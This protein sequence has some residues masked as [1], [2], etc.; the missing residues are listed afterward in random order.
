MLSP[1]L[2]L[3]SS[4]GII[5]MLITP[6]NNSYNPSPTCNDDISNLISSA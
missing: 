1:P 2:V 5:T 3:R 6:L 4:A